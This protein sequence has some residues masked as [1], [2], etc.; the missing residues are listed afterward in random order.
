MIFLSYIAQRMTTKTNAAKDYNMEI[1]V[2]KTKG[3][4]FRGKY[5][6][7]SNTIVNGEPGEQVSHFCYK[8]TDICKK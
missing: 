6:I 3:M 2:S 1:P 7:R 4:A 8:G 5:V